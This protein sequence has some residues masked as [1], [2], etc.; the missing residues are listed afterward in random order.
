MESDVAADDFILL[1]DAVRSDVSGDSNRSKDFADGDDKLTSTSRRSD[2]DD[3]PTCD[4]PK[5][6]DHD[7]PCQ[8]AESLKWYQAETDKLTKQVWLK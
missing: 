4:D 3:V 7:D 6:L 1:G 8:M 5:C 2:H